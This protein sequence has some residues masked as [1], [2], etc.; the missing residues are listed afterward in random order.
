VCGSASGGSPEW[1][2]ASARPKI[3]FSGNPVFCPQSLRY[4]V[5]KGGKQ[6]ESI[7]NRL[8]GCSMKMVRA[9]AL[10]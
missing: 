1:W 2:R 6:R 4:A 7:W 5:S 10:Q 3:H 9:P 8:L